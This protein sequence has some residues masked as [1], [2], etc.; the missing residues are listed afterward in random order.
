MLFTAELIDAGEAFRVGLVDDVVDAATGEE[1]LATLTGV[2][3]ARS[4]VTQ[5]ATKAMVADIAAHGQVSHDVQRR[6]ADIAADAPDG[7]EGVAAF[8]E[9]RP[10]RFTWSGSD[11]V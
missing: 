5:A 8:V 4:L 10:P 6:W 1:R 3:T 11:D 7:R 9:K 2:L